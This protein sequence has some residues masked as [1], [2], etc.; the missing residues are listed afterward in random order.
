MSDESLEYL[1]TGFDPSTLTVPRIRSILVSHN[2]QYPSGAKKPQLIEIFIDQVVPQARKILAARTRAKRSSTGIVDAES[3]SQDCTINSTEGFQETMHP[4]STRK[5]STREVSGRLRSDESESD[6][7]SARATRSKS[8]TKKTPR[9]SSKHPRA[10]DTETGED[11]DIGRTVRKTRK[12]E[13]PSAPTP[14]PTPKVKKENRDP[15]RISN[16][17]YDNPFQSGSSPPTEPSGRERSRK[18]L[19]ATRDKRKSTGTTSRRQ[20]ARLSKEEEDIHPPTSSRF[21]IPV[22]DLNFAGYEDYDTVPSIE[23]TE[24]F[25][26]EAQLELVRD[27]AAQGL[28]AVAPRRTKSSARGISK[29]PIWVV[30]ATV[31]GGYALWYRQEKVVVGYCGV[32]RGAN[33]V[34]P[35]NIQVPDW[36]RLIVEPQCEPCPQH[37]YCLQNLETH[38]ET[39]FVLKPHSL[40]V[41]GLVP[42]VPTC[43]PDGEKARRVKAV[44]D[45]AVEELRERRAK[46]ECGELGDKQ[47]L[48]PPVVEI[49]ALELKKEVSKKRRKG[50][51]ESEFEEL[52][53]GAIGEIERRDEVESQAAGLHRLLTSNSLARL[54]LGCAIRRSFRLSLERHRLQIATLIG[55]ILGAF[56]LRS[57]F[58]AHRIT[59]AAIPNLV[60]LTLDRLATQASLHAQ[61]S[62]A[63]SENWIAIGQLRD[64]VLRDEHSIKKRE[65]VWKKVRAVVEMNSNIRSSQRESRNGEISRAWEWI[66]AL[67]DVSEALGRRRKS[68]RVSW[69]AYD[70]NSS[71]VSGT[72]N[73]P[74]WEESR[75]IY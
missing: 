43:E 68:G 44:A 22:K 28:S 57:Q 59:R 26:P 15:R 45:R 42:L 36:A 32:G 11:T 39:D 13:A 71:P 47:G 19:G 18:S 55:L 25:T 29:G 53:G 34:I 67:E 4:P 37:A 74:R 54:P 62:N 70:K 52:W 51:S 73:G 33:Q 58:R 30:L 46:F 16:F 60:A 40:S 20:T 9:P 72:D 12:S 14:I 21:K 7:P 3:S 35:A 6:I 66:G 27:R 23:P 31:L 49:D 1:Q 65:A 38:C 8:P 75:P 63:Y 2:I 69:G 64:D 10:S 17:S 41:G 5:R 56:Y 48:P 61:D 24:E 50:M